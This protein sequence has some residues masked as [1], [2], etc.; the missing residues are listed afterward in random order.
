MKG[1]KEYEP[2]EFPETENDSLFSSVMVRKSEITR[3]S[4]NTDR[5]AQELE[6]Q[7]EAQRH[8]KLIELENQDRKNTIKQIVQVHAAANKA[9]DAYVNGRIYYSTNNVQ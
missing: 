2:L 4:A 7:R 1:K 9:K 8:Q 3:A 6:K 5:E